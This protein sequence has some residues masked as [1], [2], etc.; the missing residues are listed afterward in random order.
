MA[1]SHSSW[2][3]LASTTCLIQIRSGAEHHSILTLSSLQL[4]PGFVWLLSHSSWFCLN[5][6][7]CLIQIRSG[8]EHRIPFL[9]FKQ[10]AIISWFCVASFPQLLVLCGFHNSLN[11]NPKR[12]RTSD[13]V[14]TFV[15]EQLSV[16]YGYQNE[17]SYN[18]NHDKNIRFHIS[19]RIS[20]KVYKIS[21]QLVTPRTAQHIEVVQY[22]P[23]N[24]LAVEQQCCTMLARPFF[25]LLAHRRKQHGHNIGYL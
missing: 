21:S 25:L 18:Q 15:Q 6:T 7:T 16:S 19:G 20:L 11:T 3:C 24:F 2:F 4:S 10:F 5:S 13:F 9:T 23:Q 14:L 1:S 17:Y 8:A 22:N 12:S